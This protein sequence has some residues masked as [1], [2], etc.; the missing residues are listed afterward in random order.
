[1]RNNL[2]LH[3]HQI[4][5]AVSQSFFIVYHHLL[6]L[7]GDIWL[8]KLPLLESILVA[9]HS[10]LVLG[11]ASSFVNPQVIRLHRLEYF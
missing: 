7:K 11:R 6:K 3:I 9:S 10:T 4:A 2:R 8:G 5:F 1:M